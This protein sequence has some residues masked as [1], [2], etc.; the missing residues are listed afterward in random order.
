L[1]ALQTSRPIPD[2]PDKKPAQQSTDFSAFAAVVVRW[3]K[4]HGRNSLPWQNTRDPYLVWL[5]EIM[6]QQTQVGTVLDYFAR[7]VQR[8][9]TVSALAA[10]SQ[11]EV[12]A[13]W[14]GLGY[15]S[16]A[17][18]LHR[19]AQDV[20]ALHAGQF[21]GSAEQLQSLP[22]IGRST[23]AAIA[24]FCFGE[25]VAILDGNVKRVLARV[26]GYSADLAQSA[27]ERALW[28]QAT[29]LLPHNDLPDA[30]PRYTQGLMDLG[31]TL[32]TLRQP[33]CLLCPVQKLCSG[34]A[35]G[36]PTRY[37]V[38]TRKLKRSAQALSLLWAQQPDG[39]VWLEKRPVPGIWGGLYCLP[40]FES[41][42]AL[43]AHLPT[44]LHAR[45]EPLPR[46]VHV[47]THKDLHLSPWIAGFQAGQAMPEALQPAL[48]T[49]AWFGPAAWPA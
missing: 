41:D 49:G 32:C 12:L 18:N 37:P 30:M 34:L 16:R 29:A 4:S 11:D 20:M 9:P 42:D 31:A 10:A 35:A 45:L 40:V 21:P 39:S 38:K 13:L 6:L 22:G 14:S 3:Q 1:A 47:L 46:F 36:D 33:Q 7:F 24:S 48:G 28:D 23:A 2:N 25:R 44:P 43:K 27:N 26:L 17:R 5:S 15:Y 8:F 19:C